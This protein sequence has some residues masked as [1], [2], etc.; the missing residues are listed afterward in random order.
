MD[1]HRTLEIRRTHMEEIIL[2]YALAKPV[3]TQ[4]QCTAYAAMA[5]AVN[6]H[7]A[8]CAVGDTL[9]GIEDKADCY[10]V[11]EDETVPEPEPASAL[12]TTEERLA[13]LE[14]GLI[15]LAAQEV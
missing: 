9:W 3:E 1:C 6:A 10:E 12:P 4:E 5:E 15:E 14:A 2:G 7:N 11:A 13:A 8:A